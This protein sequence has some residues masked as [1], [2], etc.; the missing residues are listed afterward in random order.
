MKTVIEISACFTSN[1]FSAV[2]WKKQCSFEGIQWT[3]F[4]ETL[5]LGYTDYDFLFECFLPTLLLVSPESIS[6]IFVAVLCSINVGESKLIK[7]YFQVLISYSD[8][9][10]S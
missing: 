7:I 2:K 1:K 3:L 5:L 4:S 9:E 6:Y 10:K 8:S